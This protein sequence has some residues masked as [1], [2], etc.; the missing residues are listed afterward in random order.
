MQ[1]SVHYVS[2]CLLYESPLS[3]HSIHS[4]IA[5]FAEFIDSLSSASLSLSLCSSLKFSIH[6]RLSR[7][8]L[9]HI[10]LHNM[11]IFLRARFYIL[12]DISHINFLLK[13]RYPSVP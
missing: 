7:A 8:A 6:S 2:E 9:L 5:N 13:T 1:S 10:E 12:R 3:V 4:H 11:Y